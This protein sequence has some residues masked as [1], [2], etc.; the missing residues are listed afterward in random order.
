MREHRVNIPMSQSTE[1]S[2]TEKPQSMCVREDDMLWMENA[3]H[4]KG[5]VPKFW[6]NPTYLSLS[7]RYFS[8]ASTSINQLVDQFEAMKVEITQLHDADETHNMTNKI[9]KANSRRC[10]KV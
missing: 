4:M 1:G 8:F 7:S 2:S 5:R 3:Q 6:E 9:R 10:K